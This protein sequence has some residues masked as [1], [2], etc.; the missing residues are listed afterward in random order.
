MLAVKD[1]R[2]SHIL[3]SVCGGEDIG[4]DAGAS[5]SVLYRLYRRFRA[6]PARYHHEHRTNGYDVRLDLQQRSSTLWL[7]EARSRLHITTI[8]TIVGRSHRRFHGN[9]QL[10]KM[11][12][13]RRG[14]PLFQ[15]RQLPTVVAW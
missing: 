13:E 7:K 15:H 1:Q 8:G 14:H 3:V 2:S 6:L 5:K 10:Q 11:F 9:G 4:L 12:L